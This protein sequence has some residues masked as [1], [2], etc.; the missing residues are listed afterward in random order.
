MQPMTNSLL[1]A[2]NASRTAHEL[3]RFHLRM[4]WA[5]D[6]ADR[7]PHRAIGGGAGGGRGGGRDEREI[8]GEN[9]IVRR[10]KAQPVSLE[11][12]FN[13]H[14]VS[15]VLLDMTFKDWYAL[16]AIARDRHIRHK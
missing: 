7:R 16:R 13:F 4:F 15:Q 14:R 9:S 6:D 3:L 5:L 2:R 11:L 8:A 10:R 1:A 12:L